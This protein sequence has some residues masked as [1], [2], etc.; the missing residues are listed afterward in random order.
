TGRRRRAQSWQRT[1]CR[2]RASRSEAARRRPGRSFG[3]S[4]MNEFLHP[5]LIHVLFRRDCDTGVDP[6]L[7]LLAL[8]VC[9]ERLDGEVAH[10][11][12]ILED[13]PVERA[14]LQTFDE[15]L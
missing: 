14:L 13:E 4:R 12:R 1:P 5:G 6:A 10:L 7:D 11:H 8:D 9:D 2:C 3:E 15:I